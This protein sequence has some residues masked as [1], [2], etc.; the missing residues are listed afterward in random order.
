MS[1]VGVLVALAALEHALLATSWQLPLWDL[2]L[3][4]RGG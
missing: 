3:R 4:A 1:L 2:F